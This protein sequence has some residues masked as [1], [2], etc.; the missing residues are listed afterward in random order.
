[1]DNSADIHWGAVTALAVFYALIFALAA[2]ASRRR[3]TDADDLMLAGRNL[4][5]W[6]AASTMA[7]TW[8][9]GGYINGTA[10]S[11]YASGLV[12]VQAPWGYALSL[13]VGGLFYA[14]IMRRHEFTTMLDPLQ[15][16]FGDRLGAVLYVPA[17][18]GEVFWSAAILTALGSTFGVVLGIDV[19]AGHHRF[20][21]GRDRLHDDR[22][23][24]GGGRHRC[25][26]VG[27]PGGGPGRR[28]AAG[29]LASGWGS[30]HVDGL[31][32]AL[33][34]RGSTRPAAGRL[35]TARVVGRRSGAGGTRRYCWCSG[36]SPG[37]CTS[38][39]SSP[40]AT[41]QQRAGCR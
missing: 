32:R 31:H 16:R 14:P 8:V 17:F 25:C 34:R 3:V 1:M 18:T 26:P 21:R 19:Q 38:S 7:A 23:T 24:V 11:A 40:P 22:R 35:A 33:R 5:L 9:G 13:V 30:E 15:Q 39:A 10:E 20:G 4:P 37:T 2:I 36:E 6:L 29:R 41:L 28:H 12:W 27:G